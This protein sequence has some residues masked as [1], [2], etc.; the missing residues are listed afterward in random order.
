MTPKTP[1]PARLFVLLA[2]NAPV[3]VILRRGPSDWVQLIHWDTQRDIFKPGQWFHGRIYER[4]CDLSPNG[5]FFVYSAYKPENR[6]VNPDY[7]DRWTA[8]SKPP[9][10]SAL[11]LWTYGSP[12]GGGGYFLKNK[13]LML[14]HLEKDLAAHK[15]HQPERLEIITVDG[16]SF[17]R[18]SVFYHRLLG[19]N[20]RPE[21]PFRK[22]TKLPFWFKGKIT[23]KSDVK[24]SL[25][26]NF[27]VCNISY[28]YRPVSDFGVYS[29]TLLYEIVPQYHYRFKISTLV[30]N[31]YPFWKYEE[32]NLSDI[33][34][35]DF[36]QQ[37]RLVLAKAGKLF[38]AAV[39]DGELSYTELADFNA[40]TPEAI[41][42]PDWAKKW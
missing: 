30:S 4:K 31:E 32:R 25:Q 10:F 21:H 29:R 27:L 13:T 34:W 16:N 36:D 38:S 17:M 3:G 12:Y 6:I 5:Q 9:Y 22:H 37:K 11:A 14:N 26:K 35:A 40:N 15:N 18:N 28:R 20:W 7:G 8:V 1:V 33:T 42:S 24:I 19:D 2:R 41:E 23:P 39:V